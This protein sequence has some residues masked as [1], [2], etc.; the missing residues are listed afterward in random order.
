MRSLL[1]VPH[2]QQYSFASHC[3][4]LAFPQKTS[5]IQCNKSFYL[6]Q[7]C[8]QY[9]GQGTQRSATQSKCM[10]ACKNWATRS[11]FFSLLNNIHYRQNQIL[12]KYMNT[13]YK[14][15]ALLLFRMTRK[16]KGKKKKKQTILPD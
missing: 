14:H 9:G 6:L 8:T 15:R 11:G 10:A 1:Y 16:A 5:C 2:P 4:S 3:N 7:C 12:Q 13:A